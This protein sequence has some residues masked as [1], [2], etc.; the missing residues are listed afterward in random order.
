MRSNGR[1]FIMAAGLA[2]AG[3]AAQ[4]FA[5]ATFTRLGTLADLN[6]YATVTRL[7]RDG[8]AASGLSR[9]GGVLYHTRWSEM[10]GLVKVAPADPGY[11]FNGVSATGRYGVGAAPGPSGLEA[12]RWTVAD[13]AQLLGDLTGA[14]HRSIAAAVSEDG[15]VVG[16]LANATLEWPTITGQAF[17]WTQATGMVGLGFG[18][19]WHDLSEVWA[20]TP[21]GGVM[22]GD[23]GKNLVS[24]HAFRWTQGAGMVDLGD[25]PGGPDDY[26]V[27]TDLTPD[28]QVLVGVCCP[29]SGYEAFRWTQSTGMVPLGDLPGGD[30]YSQASGVSDDGAIIVGVADWDGG[31]GDQ[32]AFIWDSTHGMRSLKTVL[33]TEHGL[34]LTGW[35]LTGASGI[36]GDGTVIAGEGLSPEGHTEGWIVKIPRA[37]CRADLNGDG[38]VDFADYLEFLNLYDLGC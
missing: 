35:T 17:R 7:S 14:P 32:K 16:G 33:E 26:S 23:T 20:M 34:D 6:P 12:Y 15:A 2:V 18:A 28:G 8:R 13:G 19:A 30:H 38:L 5:Q 36:S 11:A 1:W 21:D 31:L 9:E 4:V 27:A 3:G 37:G 22:V 29:A 25:L 24:F 10:D